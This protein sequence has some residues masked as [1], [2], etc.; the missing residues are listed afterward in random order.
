MYQLRS[1]M[2]RVKIPL[3]LSK[4]STR[5]KWLKEIKKP[6]TQS[7]QRMALQ[8]RQSLH[9]DASEECFRGFIEDWT[10]PDCMKHF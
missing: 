5:Q 3:F 4:I 6:K 9:R 8:M 10:L 2:N 1:H 7:A